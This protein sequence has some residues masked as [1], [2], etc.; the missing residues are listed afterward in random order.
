MRKKRYSIV[1][2]R[3]KIIRP[4]G[5]QSFTC[6]PNSITKNVESTKK[7]TTDIRNMEKEGLRDELL[8]T[9]DIILYYYRSKGVTQKTEIT[10]Q[11][12]TL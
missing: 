6:S 12:D 5:L 2:F 1:S 9:A 4:N 10:D 8:A 3:P 11:C 7:S